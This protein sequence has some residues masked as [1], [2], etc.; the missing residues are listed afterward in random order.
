[1]NSNQLVE[2]FMGRGMIDKYLA[3]DIVDEEHTSGKPMPVI[4]AEFE[5]I[6]S[7]KDI[8]PV[9]ASELGVELIDLDGFEPTDELLQMIPAGMARLHGAFPVDYSLDGLHVVLTDP[10]NPQA[11]EDLR[12]ALGKEV[13]IQVADADLIESKIKEYYGGEG[14]GAGEYFGGEGG[15]PVIEDNPEEQAN[16]APIIRYV[17]L[18]LVQAVKERASDIHFEPFEKEFKIRYRVDGNLA[19]MQP[20][21]L[22]LSKPIISRVKVMAHMNIS[23]HRLPQDG[24]IVKVIDG[25]QVDMRVS[26]IPTQ[27]GESV[28]LRILDRSNVSLT[29]AELGL[30]KEVD[31]YVN[32]T[33]RKPNGIFVVTGPTGAGK[34][35]TLYAALREINTTDA[36]LLT[37][38]DPV[39]YDIDGIIQVPVN[40]QIGLT[41][42][43]IL[44]AFLRQD[45]DRI[46]VGEIRDKDTAQIAIQASLT[47]HLVLSTLHTNDAP[48]AVTR[49]IDMGAEP[50]LVAASLEG[51]LGQRL[52]RRICNE[53]KA[54][55]E[56]S[57][58]ILT[59][60]GLS[61]H[62]LGDKE[63][64][65][66]VGCSRCGD[67][68]YKGRQGLFELLNVTDAIREL[69]TE[70]APTV[71]LKQK[72]I[73]QGMSTLREDGM[74][75]VYNGVT[76]I[77]E[78][79]KYT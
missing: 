62:E 27:H 5:V 72:A 19:E 55:Y 47:G 1:M 32:F 20:P 31:E 57:R 21:P 33:I 2:I 63:F 42:P 64:Y 54:S 34:T 40:E 23:E 67:T 13:I 26:S 30:P 38:E 60:L 46:L 61:A 4:L 7:P 51:V 24:R 17:D 29:L 14:T 76:T 10:L 35:T 48:G 6:S 75:N 44:R 22:R 53:C 65:T 25:K 68:G 28:V 49:L 41:F 11:A 39:E 15:G 43:S 77:E 52:V 59:Q 69:I 45:P 71:V 12:F 78:V 50:F 36:K 73:E 8:W 56:P 18:V 9:I 79:L 66:G 37:A 74:H 3:Q 58:S 16:S 70:R